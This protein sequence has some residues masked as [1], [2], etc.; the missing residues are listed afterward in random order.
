MRL[1]SCFY[2]RSR[3]TAKAT[4]K[5]LCRYSLFISRVTSTYSVKLLKCTQERELESVLQ[6]V[7]GHYS[8]CWR[9]NDLVDYR[10]QN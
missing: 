6:E 3:I 2:K 1:Q 4:V 8:G 10:K 7:G 9:Y 5:A